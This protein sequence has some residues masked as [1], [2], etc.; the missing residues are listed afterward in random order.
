MRR[1]EILW[2]ALPKGEIKNLLRTDFAKGLSQKIVEHRL[3]RYGDN[4]LERGKRVSIVERA[5]RQLK[6][7]LSLIL[8]GAGVLTVVLKEFVDTT[9]IALAAGINIAV[10]VFQEGRASKAFEKLEASQE[11]FATVIRD[12]ATQVVSARFLVPGDVIFVRAGTS[13][14]ADARIIDTKGV[15]VNE[16]ALTGEWLSVVKEAKQAERN[17][18]VTDRTNMLWMGTNVVSG[19]AHAVVVETGIR[20]EVGK[21]AKEIGTEWEQSTPLQHG[22]RRLA[23]SIAFVTLGAL[24]IIFMLGIF[25]GEPLAEMF[26]VAI[27]IAVAVVP[28]GLPAAVTVVLALGMESILKVNG[29]VKNLLAAE[30]LGGTTVVLTDKTGTLTE[31]RMKLKEIR[32]LLSIKHDPDRA[33][34]TMGPSRLNEDTRMVLDIAIL[35]TDAFAEGGPLGR[36]VPDEAVLHGSPVEQ[37]IL[38][39]GFSYGLTRVFLEEEHP[40][41]D[42]LEF[43]AE[44]RFSASLNKKTSDGRE[45]ILFVTGAPEVLLAHASNVLSG[46][47]AVPLTDEVR[48]ILAKEYE[49]ESNEGFRVLATG[50]RQVKFSKFPEEMRESPIAAEKLLNEIVFGGFIAFHDPVRPGIETSV[51]MVREAGARVIMVTGDQAITARNIAR[52]VGINI[53]GDVLSGSDIAAMDDDELSLRLAETHVLARILPHQKLRVV[54]ILRKQGEVVAMT[55]DGVNDAPALKAAN[56]G[57]AFGSGTDVAKEAAD[58]ILLKNSFDVITHAIAEGRKILDNIKKITAYLLSTSTSEIVVVGF[59]LI[60]GGPLPVLPAQILWTNIIE[61]GLMNFAFAFEPAEP[62]I[63]KRD[64]KTHTM[65]GVLTPNLRNL[66]ITIAVITGVL[67]IS[68]YLFLLSQGIPVEKLRTIMFAALSIDSIFFAFSLKNLKRPIWQIRIFSNRYLILSFAA[69]VSALAAAL[70]IPPVQNMLSLVPL[71][72]AELVLIFCIGII[73]LIIIELAKYFVIEKQS[74]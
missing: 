73:N 30:T 52:E 16:A 29:L 11:K 34:G 5:I 21:I 17:A 23:R 43:Q 58:I 44:N 54:N 18:P 46:G 45:R 4:A 41:L 8:I 56:I 67:L 37:A 71:L 36:I 39:A 1:R 12:G 31:A 53:S 55:G 42:S 35:S 51:R 63:M 40:P 28:E 66:I 2:H 48:V 26:L 15:S 10:G 59:A 60:L 70:F 6:S 72:P 65:H 27:A 69:S 20:T 62:D 13:V 68:I 22:I 9:V 32:P 50:Y 64:P 74:A 14:P 25:R 33:V 7:P 19:S 38:E 49:R 3:S 24:V 57:I 61:E 47:K